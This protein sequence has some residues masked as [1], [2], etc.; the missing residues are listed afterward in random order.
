MDNTSGK[1]L[2]M[3]GGPDY[4]DT[5]NGGNNNMTTAYRQP[6]SSFKGLIYG[7][8]ISKN[9]IGPESPVAD[10]DTKFGT[11]APQNYDGRHNGIMTVGTA[12][13][14]SRNIPAVKMYFLAGGISSG[15]RGSR[16]TTEH[17]WLWVLERCAP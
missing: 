4:F 6:G 14:Y 9:P 12:L 2:A 11:Y 16:E 5:E 13:A 3:V 17:P 1:L 7:I 10:V 8:A 15:S